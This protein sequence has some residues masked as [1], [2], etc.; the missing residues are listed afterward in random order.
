MGNLVSSVKASA[1]EVPAPFPLVSD[2]LSGKNVAE[3]EVPNPGNMEDLHKKTKDIIP[4][5]FDGARIAMSKP[6]S[7]QFQVVHTMTL[8]PSLTYPSG[9]RFTATYVDIDMK[10]PQEPNSILTGDVDPSGNVNA[11]MIHQFGQRWR[12]KFQAQM[13]Q[14]NN[15]SGGQGILEYRGNRFTSS[16]TGVNIDV[17]NNSGIMVLQHLYGVTP[18]IALGCEMACQYGSNVPGG[19][20]TFFSLAGRYTAPDYTCSAVVG[21]AGANLCYYQKAS[22]ELQFG[23]ELDSKI[24]KMSESVCTFA[25]QADIP[26][27]DVSIKA[28]IDSTWT[29]STVIE[30]KLQPLPV[31]LALC[32][33]LN[34]STSKFQLGCSFVVG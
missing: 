33:S 24:M 6:L 2:D 29:V 10:N 28:A 14:T 15:M 1:L 19:L 26:K 21:P 18:S 17:V 23:V 11:T 3:E 8:L 30:K 9:Y 16:I 22:D 4:S 34:H 13:S 25:Y 20:L 32:G 27:A 12:G 5:T 31:T 7:Q